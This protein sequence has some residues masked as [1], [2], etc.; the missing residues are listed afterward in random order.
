M[1]VL[2]SQDVAEHSKDGFSELRRAGSMKYTADPEEYK[3]REYKD[4]KENIRMKLIILH[5]LKLKMAFR[6]PGLNK[7]QH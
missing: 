3:E 5:R 1:E 7:T 4:G 6:Y 2:C